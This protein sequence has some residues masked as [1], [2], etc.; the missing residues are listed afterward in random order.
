MKKQPQRKFF[1]FNNCYC[2][3][4]K[5]TYVKTKNNITLG[6]LIDTCYENSTNPVYSGT[7]L[8]NSLITRENNFRTNHL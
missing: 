8:F 1:Y 3:G 6:V 2:G 4:I 7:F 5:L